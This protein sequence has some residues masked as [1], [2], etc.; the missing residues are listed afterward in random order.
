MLIEK[1]NQAVY[2]QCRIPGMVITGQGT[3]L[4]YYE[5]RKTK[6]DWAD[7]DIKIIRSTDDGNTW[8]T[9]R[10][11]PGEGNTLNNPVMFVKGDQLHLL[12]F[13]NYKELFH[14]VSSDD[15]KTFSEPCKKE[16]GCDRFYNAV[17]VGPGHG[18][19][20][21]GN[22]IVPIWFAYHKENPKSHRPSV[23][24]TLY[25]ADGE[26]W[27]LGEWIGE[28]FLVNPTESALAVTAEGEVVISIRNENGSHQRAFAVSD[29]GTGNWRQL[30]FDERFPD[31]VCMGSMCH[32]KESIYHVNCDCATAR[33]NLTVK[34]SRDG[35]RSFR[36]VF[37]DTPAGYADIGLKDGK[38]YVF[39]E[40]DC[41]NGGLYFKKIE[42]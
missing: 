7:I 34:I 21:N 36:S 8:E 11:F 39:Y 32:D 6:D 12:F 19:I 9:V 33:E 24:N 40:R 15:G 17:A 4:A 3:I 26:T 5:C 41:E 2:A 35:F 1:V 23:V 22:M 29:T 42:L 37:V 30:R 16:I 38:L 14:C 27:Q 20:Y 28:D 31:P 25:S 18:I 10:V 13:K